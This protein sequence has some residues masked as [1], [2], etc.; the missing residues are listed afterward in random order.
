[1]IEKT[2]AELAK[3]IKSSTTASDG[4]E[5]PRKTILITG[6]SSGIG[7]YA[8]KLLRYSHPQ[9]DLVLVARTERKA[10]KAKK[11]VESVVARGR[12]DSDYSSISSGDIF[13]MGCDQT[14]LKGVRQFASDLRSKLGSNRRLDVVCLNAATLMASELPPQFTDD[15]LEV[16]FQTNYLS[17]FVI[18]NLIHDLIRP[19]GRV[20][21]STSGL[22]DRT[23]F[24]DFCGM[25]DPSSSEEG[26]ATKAIRGFE[27]VHGK[28]Y[29]Y[30]EA[31]AM[32]K[33]CMVAFA[34]N[35]HRRFRASNR[36]IVVNCFTPGLI[37]HTG[38]F[39]HQN[40]WFMPFFSFMSNYMGGKGGRHPG[41]TVEWGGGALAWMA[42]ADQVGQQ[43]GLYY[44]THPGST[45]LNPDYGKEA[46]CSVNVDSEA[47][48]PEY[49]E[50]LWELSAQLAGI[51]NDTF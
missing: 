27:T 37:T 3:V 2:L 15:N 48:N 22:H 4:Q 20:V 17:A 39:R 36:N 25:V 7:L 10:Q 47:H 46:F 43:S 16:M 5:A 19:G 14:S 33:L 29:Q 24:R 28:P 42:V 49:Q 40:K 44:K 1:M 50:K 18:L 32:S 51:P 12:D 31:Y 13:P 8:C 30:K 41:S 6:C 26:T 11:E 23:G 21:V 9:H 45:H 38:L 34:L 35:A